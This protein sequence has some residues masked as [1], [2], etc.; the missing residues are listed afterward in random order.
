M[1]KNKNSF[2]MRSATDTDIASLVA[3]KNSLKPDNMQARSGFILGSDRITYHTWIK[4]AVVRVL[5][6]GD[7][8]GGYAICL[9]DAVLRASPLWHKRE[10]IVWTS[11]SPFRLDDME[12]SKIAYFEQLGVLP[13]YRQYALFLAMHV[14]DTI[15]TAGHKHLFLTT[16]RSPLLNRAV[17]GLLGRCGAQVVGQVREHYPAYGHL[18]SDVH[19]LP[20]SDYHKALAKAATSRPWLRA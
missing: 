12:H 5:Q 4:N 17:F 11:E 16:L 7:K 18:V 10:Q 9:P 6:V 14:L 3:I 20:R 19:H 1:L 13:A 8:I 15:F 2:S